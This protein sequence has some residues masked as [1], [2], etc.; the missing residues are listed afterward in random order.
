MAEPAK[1]SK[2]ACSGCSGGQ[3]KKT[4]LEGVYKNNPV[5]VQV[6]G[7][8]SVLAVTT[9]LEPALVMGAALML[10]GALSSFFMSLIRNVT[11]PRIRM[12]VEI[13]LIAVFV[14]VFDQALKALYWDMSR[15]LGPYV[16][17]IITNCILM[18]RLEAFALQNKPG[19]SMLD[20]FANGLGYALVLAAVG[21]VREIVGAGTLLGHA[22]LPGWVPVNLLF[23]LSPGA[24]FTI[25][26]LIWITNAIH[27]LKPENKS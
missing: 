16:G 3:C 26:F 14:I 11:P 1:P 24:F 5:L 13:S 17:L 21:A 15:Q 22:V 12:I 18:G 20:G 9:K 6:I 4:L 8:C 10:T 23:L 25:G 7:I 2:A 27:P 19:L